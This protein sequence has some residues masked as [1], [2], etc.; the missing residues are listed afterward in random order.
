[1][2]F[3]KCDNS[4]LDTEISLSAEY[5]DDTSNS[6]V[7]LG[8]WKLCKK[9]DVKWY[10][11]QY[12]KVIVF[13]QEQLVNRDRN[14]VSFKYFKMICEADEVWDYDEYNIRL[15][16][17]VRP[18]V[19]LKIL[20]PC[21]ELD[22]GCAEKTIDVLFYG[23]VNDR[24]RKILDDIVSAGVNITVLEQVFGEDLNE[25]ISK[26]KIL[27]NLHKHDTA[28][29]EQARLIRWISSGAKI[30]SEKSRTNYLGVDEVDVGDIPKRLYMEIHK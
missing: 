30:I 16:R 21:K 15:L 5:K 11:Q 3:V 25:Y 18:D 24:R 20:K 9:H 14:Y 6:V 8:G 29:Q 17:T 2:Q 22:A 7:L 27:L 28:L 13:N 10:K 4:F 19:K 12:G 23:V 1:M 26:S